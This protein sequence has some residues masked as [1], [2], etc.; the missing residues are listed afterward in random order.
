MDV[1][2][3][4]GGNFRGSG[5][6]GSRWTLMEVLWKQPEVCD[7]RGSRWKYVGVYQSSWKLSRNMFVEAAIN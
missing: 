4:V 5:S 3:E 7:I 2:M 6:N 1:S